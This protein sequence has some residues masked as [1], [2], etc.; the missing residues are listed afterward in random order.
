MFFPIQGDK[1]KPGPHG[2]V[3]KPG[4]PVRLLVGTLN[5]LFNFISALFVVCVLLYRA[6]L[7][8]TVLLELM[9]TVE[10]LVRMDMTENLVKMVSRDQMVVPV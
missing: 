4:G 9:V 2:D 1:G 8:R 7:V 3:G 5:C 6:A 10:H